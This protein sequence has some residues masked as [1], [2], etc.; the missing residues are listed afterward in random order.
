MAVFA[1]YRRDRTSQ[2]MWLPRISQGLR[3]DPR[4]S[5]DTPLL[6][7]IDPATIT[8]A[9]GHALFD[10]HIML[11]A[12]LGPLLAAMS[13]GVWCLAAHRSRGA[14]LISLGRAISGSQSGPSE[15]LQTIFLPGSDT[16]FDWSG[17]CPRTAPAMPFGGGQP[18]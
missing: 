12:Y 10:G 4:F 7:A 13:P 17:A 18:G 11:D 3:F 9:S 15:V 14:V 8:F 1:I 5:G 2:R 16:D 6:E